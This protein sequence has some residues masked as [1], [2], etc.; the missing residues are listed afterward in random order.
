MANITRK[1]RVPYNAGPEGMFAW[2]EEN[3]CVKLRVPH[4]VWIPLGQVAKGGKVKDKVTNTIIDLEPYQRFWEYQ[5]GVLRGALEMDGNGYFKHRLIVL[6]WPR[7]DGKSFLAC[8]IQMWKFFCF[9]DQLITL[10]ANSK[11][12]TKFV[13]FD[14][15]TDTIRNSPKLIAAV[16]E[17]NITT[18]MITRRDHRG[19]TAGSIRTI[20]TASG[21]VSNITGYTFSEIFAMKNPTFFIQLDGSI[22][23]MPNALGVIDT[24]VSAKNHILYQLYTNSIDG[25]D[26]LTYFSYRYSKNADAKDFW[27]PQMTQDQLNSYKIKYPEI[28]FARYF[29]NTWSSGVESY[30]SEP[31]IKSME[32]IGKDGEI[33]KQEDIL[34][35]MQREIDYYEGKQRVI[36]ESRG[37]FTM[38]ELMKDNDSLLR[39]IDK[40]LIRLDQYASCTDEFGNNRPISAKELG[41]L[42]RLYNTDWCI[43]VGLDRADPESNR[44]T[45]ARTII[46]VVAKGM[47]GSKVLSSFVDGALSNSYIYFLLYLTTCPSH[48]G[49]EIKNNLLY[50]KD[51]YGS[52]DKFT[53][54]R[55][56]AWDFP[57]WCDENDI[58]CELV[59]PNYERQRPAFTE[60]HLSVRDGRFKAPKIPVK[61]IKG[62]D[63]LREEMG[64][65]THSPDPPRFFGSPEKRERYGIQDDSLFSLAW[66]IYGGRELTIY[67]FHSVDEKRNFGI[68]EYD[69]ALVGAY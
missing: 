19:F 42:G 64:V 48:T 17:R 24:T 61:G 14:I 58:G 43:L 34:D 62:D 8:L 29:K 11:D 23:N 46:T 38:N 4:A 60:L 35:L 32:Y 15:M 3:V 39:K 2:A 12:Q 45:P 50:I 36:E 52:I 26:K 25:K 22:R 47:R 28:E 54:E 7:G 41:A 65:F 37:R 67:D 5:K 59:Y 49:E 63:V 51:L 40:E 18:N 44:R 6:C 13:H 9:E 30:F 53:S 68:I 16:G 31:A 33:G 69:R 1:K 27:H 20:S 56:G 21:I 57:D 10:G 55:W 66:C